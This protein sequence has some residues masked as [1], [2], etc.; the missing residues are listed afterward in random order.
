MNEA[1]MKQLLAQLVE[2]VTAMSDEV[3][4]LVDLFHRPR[5]AAEF[6]GVAVS[7]SQA[8]LDS[9]SKLQTVA[10]SVLGPTEKAGQA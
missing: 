7:R 8:V 1:D 10:R 6:Q 3:A 9:V 4:E 2:T 5:L